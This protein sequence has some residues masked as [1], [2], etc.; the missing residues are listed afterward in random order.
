MILNLET[1]DGILEGHAAC[2]T[3]LQDKVAK[4]LLHPAILDPIAQATLLAEVIPVFT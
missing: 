1:D 2:S 4:L 3:Y